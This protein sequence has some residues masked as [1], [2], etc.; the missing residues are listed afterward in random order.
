MNYYFFASRLCNRER[1]RIISEVASPSRRQS[2]HLVEV[3]LMGNR[4]LGTLAGTA[5]WRRVIALIADGADIAVIATATTQAALNGLEKARGD[6]GLTYSFFLLARFALAARDD[7]FTGALR[8]EGLNVSSD[9]DV[10]DIAAAFTETVD[11]RLFLTR[12]RTD[13]GEMAQLAAIEA[14][15]GLLKQG[16][17]DLFGTTPAEVSR[18]AKQL[19]TAQGFGTLAREFFAHFAQRFLTYHLGRELPLHIGGNGR[20]A[21]PQDHND[22]VN[23]LAVH[24][25]EAAAIVRDFASDWYSKALSPKG[26]GITPTRPRFRQPRPDQAE[27]PADDSGGAPWLSVTSSCAVEHQRQKAGRIGRAR[28]CYA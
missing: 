13:L 8:E 6:K 16:S 27:R 7:D 28:E 17:A 19:S 1:S 21:D 23:Q 2:L 9:P 4:R 18:E 5:P 25:R 10:F 3:N 12:R 15:T 20:F 11:Q 14:L 26:K 24:C 22:F